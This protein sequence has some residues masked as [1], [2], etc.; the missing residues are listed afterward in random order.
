MSF[1][2]EENIFKWLNIL[3]MGLCNLG[4]VID[5]SCF[6]LKSQAGCRS[7]CDYAEAVRKVYI[8][9]K[10]ISKKFKISSYQ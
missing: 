4:Q 6:T 9:I 8:I 2:L 7:W 10:H 1:L 3:A 5:S